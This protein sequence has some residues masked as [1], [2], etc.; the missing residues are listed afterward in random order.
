MP[1]DFTR[2][3]DR[4]IHAQVI[5]GWTPLIKPTQI[6]VVND[7]IASNENL[8]KI[9]LIA[10]EQIK[11]KVKVR[12]LSL[13]E[14]IIDPSLNGKDQEKIFLILGSPSDALFLIKNNIDIKKISLGCISECPGKRR[15]LETISI[16]DEDIRAFRELIEMGIEIKYQAT[17]SDKPTDIR[18]LNILNS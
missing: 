6:V 1:I 11:E 13:K 12:I 5:W 16:D 9:L 17:P 15:I 14:A 10:G 7:K 8:K 2:I 4:F 18:V 3:D